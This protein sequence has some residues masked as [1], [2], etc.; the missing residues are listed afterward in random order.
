MINEILLDFE[1]FPEEEQ[2]EFESNK[3]ARN[4]IKKVLPEIFERVEREIQNCYQMTL[5]GFY[6]MLGTGLPLHLEKMLQYA[7]CKYSY[8]ESFK[9]FMMIFDKRKNVWKYDDY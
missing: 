4:L 8:F 9:I 7:F 3:S 6:L 1:K 5:T 2:V